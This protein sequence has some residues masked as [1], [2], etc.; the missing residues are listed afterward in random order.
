[1]MVLIYQFFRDEEGLSVVEYVISAALLVVILAG[2][3]SAWQDTLIQE[4]SAL[5]N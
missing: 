5:F 2:V 1:M 3:F 4:F